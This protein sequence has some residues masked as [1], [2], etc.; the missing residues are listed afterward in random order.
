MRSANRYIKRIRY[1][2][3]RPRRG[4][5]G[6]SQHTDMCFEVV[7][8][9]GE[10]DLAAPAPQ[11]DKTWP[12][13]PDAFSSYRAGFEVRT[14]RLCRRVLVFHHFPDEPVG[15]DCLVRSTDFGYHEGPV[16]SFICSITQSGYSRLGDGKY[17]KKSLPS[18]EFAY[19]QV[20]IDETMRTIDPESVRDPFS[21]PLRGI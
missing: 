9:Y 19:S 20:H 18:L 15:R 3:R 1:G 21:H 10:H 13:R 8:D 4:N 16:A 14:Y 6:S 7:F 5:A 11:E 12:T 2:N 17:R